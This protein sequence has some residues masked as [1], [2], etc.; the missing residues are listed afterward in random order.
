MRAFLVGLLTLI[1]G[2]LTGTQ[3]S[4]LGQATPGTEVTISTSST[5]LVGQKSVSQLFS[6]RVNCLS[7]II[8]TH[9]D[10]IILNFGSSSSSG[11][12]STVATTSLQAGNGFVQ[13][14]ST[15]VA[16][17][18]GIYGCGDWKAAGNGATSSIDITEMR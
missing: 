9:G 15:T 16:Y 17:D 18:A 5:V 11:A 1:L 10:P 12:I 6:P 13:A 3:V 7:R 8:G 4:H 14:A 2:L